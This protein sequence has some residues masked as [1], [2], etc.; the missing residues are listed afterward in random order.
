M[1]RL[2]IAFVCLTFC[3]AGLVQTSAAQTDEPASRDDV[4]LYLRV[5]RS[6]DM[7]QKTMAVQNASHSK[8]AS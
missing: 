2:G 7:L 6:H 5:M 1:K 4:I 8:A 3:V